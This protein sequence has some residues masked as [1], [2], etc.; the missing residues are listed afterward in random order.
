VHRD[1]EPPRQHVD[2]GHLDRRFRVEVTGA[3]L[4]HAADYLVRIA[5]IAA[6][7]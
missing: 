1:A 7:N 4:V 5:G 6:A 3:S 2:A